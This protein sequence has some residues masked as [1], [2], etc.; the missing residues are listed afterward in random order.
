MPVGSDPAL[1]DPYGCTLGSA[2]PQSIKP[3]LKN[4]GRQTLKTLQRKEFK[5]RSEAAGCGTPIPVLGHVRPWCCVVLQL[6]FQVHT[7]LWPCSAAG[8]RSFW[9]HSDT[10]YGGSLTSSS[11]LSK[12]RCFQPQK[13]IERF[14]RTPKWSN[15]LLPAMLLAGAG[16]TSQH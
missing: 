12:Q 16:V 2:W 1:K 7:F 11:F 9:T 15:S 6:C 4:K 10:A 5:P 3:L 14:I 8:E 13:D